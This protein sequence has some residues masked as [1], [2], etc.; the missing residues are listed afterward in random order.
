[1]AFSVSIGDAI[2]LSK[3]AM[4]LGQAFTSGR[5]SAQAEFLEVQNLLYT[6]SKGLEML[7]RQTP[8]GSEMESK[9]PPNQASD[10]EDEEMTEL[11]HIIA[12]C[13]ETLYHLES[14]V[15]KYSVLDA[16]IVETR[17]NRMRRWNDELFKNWKKV[18][19][20]TKGGDIG[21]LKVTLTAH[22]NG[23]N[24]AVSILNRYVTLVILNI[25]RAIT[26]PGADDQETR[27][28]CPRASGYDPYKIRRNLQL[29][30][31]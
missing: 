4:Q 26:Q 21:I 29:V 2:M 10:K 24:L 28:G 6:L 7:A 31:G 15:I 16:Q 20:T 18:I 3:I 25:G 14:V 12:N 30:Y 5:K 23:L 8:D 27:Q 9:G 17:K 11:N 1:M 13:R 22:I 19:W